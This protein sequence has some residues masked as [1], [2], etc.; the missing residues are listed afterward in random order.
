MGI[1]LGDRIC[2]VADTR[3]SE[4]NPVTGEF[5]TKHDDMLKIEALSDTRGAMIA[6]A[7]NAALAKRVLKALNREF[8]G[9]TIVDIRVGIVETLRQVGEE[10]GSIDRF[11]HANFLIAGVDETSRKKISKERFNTIAMGE[12]VESIVNSSM[13]SHFADS[14][15]TTKKGDTELTLPLNNTMLFSVNVDMVEGV[16]V[17]DSQWG[18][19]L[20]SG[21]TMTTKEDVGD[22]EIAKLEFDNPTGGNPQDRIERDSML[23]VAIA[24]TMTRKYEWLTVGGAYIPIQVYNTGHAVTLPRKFMSYDPVTG[25]TQEVSAHIMENGKFYRMDEHGSKHRLQLVSELNSNKPK[26]KKREEGGELQV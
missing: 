24:S 21:P 18:D 3:V 8:K 2:L 4:K 7:G 23:S 9:K 17:D 20:V 15:K 1:N 10:F 5:Q 12:H 19:A 14:L 6:S 16:N 13:A 11:A 22:E 26:K 25:E